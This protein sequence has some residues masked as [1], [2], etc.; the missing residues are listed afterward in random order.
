MRVRVSGSVGPTCGYASATLRRNSRSSSTMKALLQSRAQRVAGAL[1]PHLEGRHRSAGQGGH[2]GVVQSLAVLEQE[3][4]AQQ[5]L[6]RGE[7][8]L[9][10]VA[11][12]DGP[13]AGCNR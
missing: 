8:G 1:D 12:S 7:G 5:R 10:L 11:L 2:R 6:Q 13:I 9:Q 4:F 3:R